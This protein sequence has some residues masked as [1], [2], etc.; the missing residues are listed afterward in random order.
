VQ[1]IEAYEDTYI[2]YSLGNLVFGGNVDPDDRDAYAA[3][4]TFTVY[5]DRCDPPQVTIVPLRLTELEDGTDY[6]PIVA[7]GDEA[8]RIVSRI[9]KRSHKM[10]NFENGIW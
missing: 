3:R 4:L 7:E 6:R 10:E 1:G 9:L 5:E 2:L 8:D